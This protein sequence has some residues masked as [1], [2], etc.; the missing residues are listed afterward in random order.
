LRLFRTLPYDRRAAADEPGAALWFPRAFQG[1]GRHDNPDIY[2]C[3]YVSEVAVSAVA[4]ALAVFRG[5]GRLR[6]TML[7][8]F[9]LRLVLIELDLADGA[10]LVDLDDPVVLRRERLRPSRVATRRR[11]ETRAQA[12]MLYAKHA[13]VA[14]LR[15][16][17]A[18]EASWINVTLFDRAAGD[19]AVRSVERLELDHPA[20]REAAD[21]LGLSG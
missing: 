8:R 19:L 2:G 9:G 11:S 15:W 12:S 10:G 20:V 4:E 14:G 17:S 5:S 6:P 3:L 16:W 21:F 13:A 1:E 7:V 18:L